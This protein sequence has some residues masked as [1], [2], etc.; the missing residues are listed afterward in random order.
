M[1]VLNKAFVCSDMFVIDFLKYFVGLCDKKLQYNIM[2]IVM[3]CSCL[4]AE[5]VFFCSSLFFIFLVS[6]I[7]HSCFGFVP[8]SETVG[9]QRLSVES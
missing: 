9:K 8:L 1:G 3:K 5:M 2:C 7:E 4:M 6:A